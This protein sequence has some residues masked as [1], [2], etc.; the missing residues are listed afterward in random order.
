MFFF[1]KKAHLPNITVWTRGNK[2]SLIGIDKQTDATYRIFLDKGRVFDTPESKETMISEAPWRNFKNY[3]QTNKQ[4]IFK[5]TA[6]I[7]RYPHLFLAA[8]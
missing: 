5:L 1:W 3:K 8:H 7:P 6:A 2:S 4:H